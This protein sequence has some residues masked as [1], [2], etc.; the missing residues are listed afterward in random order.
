MSFFEHRQGVL[1][2]EDVSLAAIG[3]EVGTPVYVYSAAAIRSAARAFRDG[4]HGIA[5]KHIAFAVKA[6]PNVAIL[7]LLADERYGADIVSEG[8]LRQALAGGMRPQDVLFSGVGKSNG[9]MIAALDAGICQFNIELEEE[10]VFLS[11]LA[12]AQGTRAC[13]V[14]RINPD[15][16]AGTHPKIS[17]GQSAN[18]F[19]VPIADARSM[20]H[21]LSRLQGLRLRG[22]ALHIGSQISD[23]GRLE[24]AYVAAG[25]L[26]A[27]LRADGHAITH[28]DL[29][30]GLG[31]PYR[32]EDQFPS[33]A[34]YGAMVE[35]VTRTWDVTL[36]FEPGRLIA[37]AAGVLLT[38]VLWVKP[39]VEHPHVIVDAAM[40][41][42]ARPAM[43]DAYHR[44]AAVAPD[45]E[46][47]V[48]NIVGPVCESGDTFAKAREI[49][50][51]SRGDLAVFHTAGAYGAS[52]AS[53]YNSRALVPEVLVDGGRYSV[54]ADRGD[55]S[56]SLSRQH[57]PAWL[58]APLPALAR[59]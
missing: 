35:R 28:V 34:A 21:R 9:E 56:Q 48:A 2:A 51:V 3:R 20:Y 58:D 22:I 46:R 30:G 31:I 36:M 57:V 16:A 26:V 54:V 13:A 32:Q 43:Y 50:A 55:G 41:D 24:E 18:K 11:S 6:N 1:H 23:L 47:L 59:A 45:G 17:T 4:L 12:Q 8:E 10:G 53:T 52:M 49:D 25:A 42:L 29:G 7:R 5:R 40:N 19:G 39:G 37:G 33:P 15:V 14:L 44:F 38:R 27:A